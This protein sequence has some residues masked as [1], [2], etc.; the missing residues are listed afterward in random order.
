MVEPLEDRQLLATFSVTNT[1]NSGAGS[2]RQAI[3][4]ANATAGPDIIAFN[5]PGGGVQTIAPTSPLPTITDAVTI[6]G[7]S[8]PGASPNTLSVGSNA[9]LLIELSGASAGSGAVG[10]TITAAGSVI[11]GLVIN[12]FSAHGIRITGAGATGNVIAGN[13]IGTNA[14]G[15][16][17][18]P[19]IGSGVRID[20]G[21]QANRIGTNGDGVADDAERNV[22]SGNGTQGVRITG[23]GTNSNVVAGN[24]IGTNATGTAALPN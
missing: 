19:N 21:A 20:T 13:Y 15:T 16:A 2:L 22:I 11:Q 3:L 4:D 1:L 14:T 9:V 24:Y 18:L 8:Q 12:R 5:I 7:Y 23:S 17:A 10:L 6:D